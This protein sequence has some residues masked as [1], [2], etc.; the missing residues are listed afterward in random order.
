MPVAAAERLAAG[1]PALTVAALR[2]AD[3]VSA[4]AYGLRRPGPGYDFWQFRRYRPG[5]PVRAV[6]W[7]RSAREGRV[8]VSERERDAA[9]TFW[10]WEDRSASMDWR[11][12]RVQATKAER[13][14]LLV[15]AAA[16]LLMRAGHQV[17][18][19]GPAPGRYRHERRLGELSLSLDRAPLVAGLPR[20]LGFGKYAQALLVGD[21]MDGPGAVEPLFRRLA[22][23]GVRGHILQVLDPAE[24]D[25]PMQGRRRFLGLEGE[26]ELLVRRVGGLR[27][28]YR[29]RLEAHNEALRRSAARLGW[30]LLRHRTDTPPVSVLLALAGQL[31]ERPDRLC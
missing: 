7:R 26:G 28:A 5:D 24:I 21:F 29:E 13:A 25:L 22:E 6:D 9:Q 1:L 17:A 8:L 10:L 2:V 23:S 20:D 4:G 31:A 3:T 11:S 15:L 27:A 30:T 16:A 14:R 19:I 12:A 18:P